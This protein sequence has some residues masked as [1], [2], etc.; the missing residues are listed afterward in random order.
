[1]LLK[2]EVNMTDLLGAVQRALKRRSAERRAAN[3]A[4][5]DALTGLFNARY[6]LRRLSE[7]VALSAREGKPCAVFLLDLDGFEPVNDEYGHAMGDAA[8]KEIASRLKD[9]LRDYDMLARLGGDEFVVLVQGVE[10]RNVLAALAQRFVELVAKPLRFEHVSITLGASVGVA[11]APECA[12]EP[13]T[14]L[15]VADRAMYAAKAAGKGTVRF[16]V[17]GATD[18]AAPSGVG[19]PPPV[20]AP[21]YWL[22]TLVDA[23]D[24]TRFSQRL[25]IASLEDPERTTTDVLR[26]LGRSDKDVDT[27]VDALRA[28]RR[29]APD[30]TDLCLTIPSELFGTRLLDALREAGLSRSLPRITFE[31]PAPALLA[32]NASQW[33]ML[34]A[35]QDAGFN[36]S[37][38]DFGTAA[39]RPDLLASLPL[40]ALRLDARIVTRAAEGDAAQRL[41]RGLV[42]FG[43]ALGFEVVVDDLRSDQQC[44]LALEAGCDRVLRRHTARE[45]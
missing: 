21:R 5:R 45:L 19:F 15:R 26:S 38:R 10:D 14:L 6:F 12:S 31:A 18:S 11:V 1:M 8:L 37:M 13:G 7:A 3:L 16:A 28:A 17:G 9:A 35:F 33:V 39:M 30:S 27:I 42:T 4:F 23:R 25:E 2:S 44:R 22:H 20:S 29:T 43:Q 36:I 32:G 41:L 34:Q 40:R 24:E